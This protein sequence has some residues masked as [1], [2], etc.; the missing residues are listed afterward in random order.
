MKI[1]TG[2]SHHFYLHANYGP[3]G[4]YKVP[5]PIP[6]TPPGIISG[7]KWNDVNINGIHDD[8][9]LPL[10]NWEISCS[11]TV[12]GVPITFTNH[13]D[14]NGL[15]SF[16]SLTDGDWTISETIQDDWTPSSATSIL[17]TLPLPTTGPYGTA[18]SRTASNVD[19]FNWKFIPVTI[20]ADKFNDLDGNGLMDG[21]DS[22]ISGWKLTI[23]C[24]NNTVSTLGSPASWNVV[25]GGR[26]TITEEDKAG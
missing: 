8:G 12:N 7:H 24:P 20:T 4:T 18:G 2:S 6:P 10:S 23:T 26:Y 5:I 9:D 21:A 16:S 15:Y 25:N 11:G 14:S 3:S 22:E 1:V 17:I 19:F 13:T